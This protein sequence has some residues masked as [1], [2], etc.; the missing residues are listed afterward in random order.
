MA[1]SGRLGLDEPTDRGLTV[2]EH[3]GSHAAISDRDGPQVDGHNR[4]EAVRKHDG[5]APVLG[6]QRKQGRNEREAC[7]MT[8]P[9]ATRQEVGESPRGAAP[10]VSSRSSFR[11]GRR[12]AYRANSRAISSSRGAI[13]APAEDTSGPFLSTRPGRLQ[14]ISRSC[15]ACGAAKGDKVPGVRPLVA[16]A[17]DREVEGGGA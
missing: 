3:H 5:L 8:S 7:F 13:V 12:A 2:G 4:L 10:G 11:L 15:H 17:V 6:A 16:D 14:P 9:A 1:S